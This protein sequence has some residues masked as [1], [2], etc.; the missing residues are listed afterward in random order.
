M[1]DQKYLDQRDFDRFSSPGKS[2]TCYKMVEID[3]EEKKHASPLSDYSCSGLRII[4]HEPIPVGQVLQFDVHIND[5]QHYEL[6]GQ[7]RWCLEVD[8]VPTYHAGVW[9][10]ENDSLD[11]EK[12]SKI[13]DH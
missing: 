3:G 7:I 9:F 1:I 6:W 10:V 2:Y 13:C 12:W 4:C 8:E 11:F 5:L